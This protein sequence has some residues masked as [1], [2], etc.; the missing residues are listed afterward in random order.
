MIRPAL[1]RLRL[2]RRFRVLIAESHDLVRLGLCSLLAGHR[3]LE[4]I[5]EVSTVAGAVAAV[6]ER[7][8]ELVVMAAALTDGTGLDGCREILARV[9]DTRVV[10]LG[11]RVDE[12][13]T[14]AAARAGA[15]GWLSRYADPHGICRLL[16]DAAAGAVRLT[17][18]SPPGRDVL[19]LTPQERRV[20][21]LVAQGKTN[22]EIGNTLGLSE[23]TVKNYLSHAFEKLSVSRRAQAAVLFTRRYGAQPSLD[24]GAAGWTAPAPAAAD[25][26]MTRRAG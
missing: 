10:I 15:L 2:Q 7:R 25:A 26:V 21:G 14:R 8:P 19:A 18:A 3:S 20:L 16:R 23:K 13:M 17:A 1:A 12:A 22:K 5:G 9:P 24:A 4:V 6:V 11:D